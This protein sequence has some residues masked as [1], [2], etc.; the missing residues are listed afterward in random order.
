MKRVLWKLVAHTKTAES[1]AL[2]KRWLEN[3]AEEQSSSGSVIESL[4]SARD[5][6]TIRAVKNLLSQFHPEAHL[7]VLNVY[8][9]VAQTKRRLAY[10]RQFLRCLHESRP[11]PYFWIQSPQNMS[12]PKDTTGGTVSHRRRIDITL[13]RSC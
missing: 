9:M 8:W 6:E 5:G 1:I 11:E 4:L 7:E 12:Q 2:P 13:P 10:H 3:R